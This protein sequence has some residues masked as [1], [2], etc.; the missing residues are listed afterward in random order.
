MALLCLFAAGLWGVYLKFSFVG[1]MADPIWYLEP[2]RNFARGWGLVSRLMLPAQVAGFPEGFHPP[3]GYLHHGPVA[4]LLIGL[5]YKIFGFKD[6]VPLAI[7]F[8]LT[9][10][11]GL[12][13]YRLARDV[14]GEAC[15]L[16][17]AIFFWSSYLIME[18][19][20]GSLTDAPFILF[21]TAA[22]LFLWKSGG[23]R[24]PL[25]WLSA[26]GFTLGLASCTRLAGQTY[27]PSFILAV[28]WLH[29]DFRALSAFLGALIIPLIPLSLYNHQAAGVYF[30]SP[31]FYILN[32]SPSF[33]GFRS[34]T[35][36]M[37]ITTLQ[38]LLSYPMDFAQKI[39]TGPAYAVNRFL[40]SAHAPYFTALVFL[41]LL[42]DYG[43]HRAAEKF[44]KLALMIIV[45]VF[46]FNAVISYGAVHYLNPLWPIFSVV[47]A[48][49]LEKF[50]RDNS[51][52][53]RPWAAL[54]V[55][56]CALLFL[57]PAALQIKDLWKTRAQR[58]ALYEDEGEMGKFAAESTGER[59][60]IYT[61]ANRAVCWRADRA[62]VA[63]PATKEDAEKT[64][65]HLPPDAI[66]LTS[67]RIHSDD[68]DQSWREAF[69]TK[70]PVM[71]FAPCAEFSSGAIQAVLFR[72]PDNC[73]NRRIDAKLKASLRS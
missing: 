26:A 25:S 51:K 56:I 61:D 57:S 64:F 5:G 69:K 16:L 59:E 19:N 43:T 38:A 63:L 73:K 71:G 53:L 46:A 68:Y 34:S 50:I 36:Y 6:C 70:T 13:L 44:R 2:A 40:E 30:Y 31:G 49:F 35:S 48:L 1:F 41:G 15:A 3:V 9:L 11:T 37:N 52:V 18:G 21:I 12:I 55:P 58:Q 14:S 17:S 4:P 24:S 29:R 28:L 65:R 66:L 42:A 10:L 67:L 39:V 22:F 72:R 23:A 27:W 33:P 7:T 20:Y 60:V 54:G 32:W 45:P 62:A 47:G 8:S